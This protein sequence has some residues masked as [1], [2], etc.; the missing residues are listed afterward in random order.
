MWLYIVSAAL[1]L[2]TY[3][4]VTM[5]RRYGCFRAKG[6]K[7]GPAYFPFGSPHTFK[8]LTGRKAF[9]LLL[10]DIYWENR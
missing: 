4:Y 6:I 10:D 2:L 8:M 1:C 7:E 5:T 3:A 9:A